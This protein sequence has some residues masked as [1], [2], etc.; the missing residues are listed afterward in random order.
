[1]QPDLRKKIPKAGRSKKKFEP[2]T[3]TAAA[4]VSGEE[5]VLW[6]HGTLALWAAV[7]IALAAVPDQKILRWKLFALEAGV[8]SLLAGIVLP[9]LLRPRAVFLRTPLDWAA[10]LYGTGSLFFYALSPERGV[11]QQELHRALFCTACFFAASQTW[12]LLN[13]PRSGLRAFMLPAAGLS[14]YALLQLHGGFWLLAVPQSD[15]PAATFGNPIFLAALLACALPA[16]LTLVRDE[17]SGPRRG[18][19]AACAAL[20]AGGIWAAQSRAA[21]AGLA[22]AAVCASLLLLRGAKRGAA[23]AGIALCAAALAWH[24]H[25]REWTHG[26]IWRDTLSLWR[27]HPWLGCGL[28]RFHVE[29]PS[30]ASPTLL[31]LWPEQ[32]I[33]INFAHNEYLQILAETGVLGLAFF[34]T[35]PVSA[36]VLAVRVKN[37]LKGEA[38]RNEPSQDATIGHSSTGLLL[39]AAVLLGQAFFSPDLR[40][41]ISGFLLFSFFGAAASEENR[42]FPLHAGAR[43]AALG[44]LLA[45]LAAW[46]SLALKPVLAYQRLAKQ[47]GFHAELSPEGERTIESL[48]ARLAANPADGDAAENLGW[49]YA[50]E[51]RW[52]LAAQRYTLAARLMPD[53]PGPLNNLGNI[54]Y[55]LGRKEEA[56]ACWTRSLAIA[57]DQLDAHLNLGKTLYEAG[58]LKESARHLQAVL[59][60]EPSNEKAQVLLK[61]MVE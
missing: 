8:F 15:R 28:G 22:L 37:R 50:K 27:S 61:K 36:A 11:S 5:S 46:G 29:F 12:P 2:D 43:T 59:Q 51:R 52:D 56:I 54:H 45:F 42:A 16:A 24:F 41:G 40:F 7:F 4:A 38:V 9:R 44:L 31:A 21:L 20:L 23:L 58:R 39:A 1:M 47:P 25:G 30:H 14:L 48:E 13:D 60:K 10:A 33:I 55:S 35:L 18:L 26:L 3:A 19:A 17:D 49:L 57:P 53:R 6:A 32:K 34:L